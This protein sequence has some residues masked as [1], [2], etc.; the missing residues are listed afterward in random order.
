MR[1]TAVGLTAIAVVALLTGC[2]LWG[3]EGGPGGT[4]IA[5][6]SP[7]AA[8]AVVAEAGPDG[9]QRVEIRMADDLRMT[10]ALV[11]AAPGA[12]EFT[13]RN[14][15]AVPHDI[16]LETGGQ[17]P[18]GS[19]NLNGGGRG[20][21]RVEVARPGRYPFPCLYHVSSGMVGTLEVR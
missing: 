7:S 19:G 14:D 10:P 3:P 15:G 17:P 20:T 1:R 6:G 12:I 16:R 8:V 13:F 4:G 21:V 2:S 9:V 5:A 18:P 11:L